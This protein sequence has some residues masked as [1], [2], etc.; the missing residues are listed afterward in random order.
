MRE[1]HSA[2]L[3]ISSKSPKQV[4]KKQPVTGPIVHDMFSLKADREKESI[5]FSA[6][7]FCQKN[8]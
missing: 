2:P 1:G 3:L 7:V 8:Q 6:K 4:L 5:S